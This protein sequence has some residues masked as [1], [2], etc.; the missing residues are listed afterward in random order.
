M[1]WGITSKTISGAEDQFASTVAKYR[2][3]WANWDVIG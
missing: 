2:S 1:G 3:A